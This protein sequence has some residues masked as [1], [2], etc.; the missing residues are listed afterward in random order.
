MQYDFD[1]AGIVPRHSDVCVIGAGAAGLLLATRLSAMGCSVTLLEGGGHGQEARS[2]KLYRGEITGLSHEGLQLGRFRAFGG[3]TT[4][5]GGQILELADFD[6]EPR[7]HVGGSGWP[8]SK[9]VLKEYYERA[10]HYEGLERTEREDTRVHAALGLKHLDIGP[11][12][13]LLYSRHCRERNFAARHEN[14]LSRSETLRTF[15]HA[16]VVGLNLSADGSAIASAKVRSFSGREAEV[17]A[18]RFVICVGGIE[19]T[20]LLLQPDGSRKVPWQVNGVLGRFFQDHILLD[21]LPL[22]VVS[23][24]LA[25]G[26]FGYAKLDGFQYRA[27]VHLSLAAQADHETLDVAGTINPFQKNIKGSER[28]FRMLSQLVRERKLPAL[29]DLAREAPYIPKNITDLL[30]RRLLGEGHAWRRTMLTLHCEQSPRS[31]SRISLSERRDMFGMQITKLHW[32]I[33][34]QEIHSLRT[35]ARLAQK[36]FARSHL[37]SLK[38][39]AGFFDDDG[40]VR[41][42]CGD[43]YHHMGG[44]PMS[45][46][47]LDGIVDTNLRLH[48]IANGYVCS[49]SVFPTSGFS[50]PTHTLLALTM[51]LSDH[52]VD[53]ARQYGRQA[54][55]TSAS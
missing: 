33:S 5:W 11:E 9:S 13:S 30:F 14:A 36:V 18:E 34:D 4:Q 46:S 48:G 40:V 22:D 10:L 53:V 29:A 25:E 52:L 24:K 28:A 8:F 42:M 51:R 37:G 41:A 47:P 32:D 44:C 49:A 17:T 7:R 19:S 26:Y 23:P 1:T 16:N 12:F 43:S 21:C 50:N 45:D 6:F 2:Q 39:P 31:A 3:S 35:F 20:R 38:T 55:V 15:F 27:H 54:Q